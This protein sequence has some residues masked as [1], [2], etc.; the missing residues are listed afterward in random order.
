MTRAA[1]ARLSPA[2][3]A[4]LAFG[5]AAPPQA[6]SAAVRCLPES[7]I[8][9]RHVAGPAAI[10]FATVGGAVYRNRLA[11]ACPGLERLGATAVIL[12]R[13]GGSGDIC[14]G[15][16]IQA[17]DPVEAKASGLAGYPQC[18]LGDFVRLR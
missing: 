16:R 1:P 14:R 13:D 12:R 6:Q 4:A 8:V 15:D 9:S 7:G 5:C 10:D 2:L 17:F 3:L 11:S 18:V